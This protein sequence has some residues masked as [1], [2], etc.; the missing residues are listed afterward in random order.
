MPQ[1]LQVDAS[2]GGVAWLTLNRPDKRNALSTALREEIAD[3]LDALAA[4]PEVKCVVI[5]GAG[6]VFCAG[7]DLREFE[8][9]DADFQKAL[10]RSSDR[11]HH[12][13]LRFP[14]P[15]IA[16]INGPALAGGFDLAVMCDVRIAASTATFAHPEREFSQ[17]V[18]APLHDLV[19]GAAARYLTMTGVTIDAVEAL[20][21]GVV[22]QVVE[23]AD[24]R[25]AVAALA[26]QTATA[27][28]DMLQSTK[29]KALRRAGVDPGAATLDL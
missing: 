1:F 7:F 29:T 2:S 12:T 16:A 4:N 13:V 17:V 24:L 19:G 22:S 21:L 20:R 10:W 28:R 18:Y 25:D 15:I 23:P 8:N 26:A 14:L 6:D 3:A 11:F 9:P 5:T 27:P